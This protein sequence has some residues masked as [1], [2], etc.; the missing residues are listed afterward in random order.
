MITI[1]TLAKARKQEVFDQIATHMLTQMKVCEL[2]ENLDN[3]PA[4]VYRNSEGLKCAAGCLI[5]DEEYNEKIG[6]KGLNTYGWDQL[7]E[8][9]IVTKRHKNIIK[10]L[11][12]IHDQVTENRWYYYLAGVAKKFDLNQKA[13]RPFKK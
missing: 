6:P 3:A 1:A 2:A 4:C 10:E 8:R 12:N 9:G 13:I 7:I 5:S 11:Q